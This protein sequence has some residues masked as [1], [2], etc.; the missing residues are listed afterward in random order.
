MRP[1]LSPRRVA[2]AGTGLMV[3]VLLVF[4]AV[5]L[6]ERG[7]RLRVERQHSELLARVLEDHATRT[8]ESVSLTLAALAD[9]V[10][11]SGPE[12]ENLLGDVL[13]RAL[14]GVPS[15]RSLALLDVRGRVLASTVA[16]ERGQLV[17][18]QRLA[19]LPQAQADTLGGFVAGRSLAAVAPGHTP[20]PVPAGVG[21]VPM[22]RLAVTRGG[23]GRLLVAL[24]NP[25]AMANYQQQVLSDT[26]RTAVLTTLDG[27]V[28]AATTGTPATPGQRLPAL[29]VFG[30]FLPAHE[31]GSYH[32]AGVGAGDRIVAFRASRS[33]PLV[34]IVELSVAEGLTVWRRDMRWM[35]LGVAL[36]VLLMGV[37]TLTAVRSLR[38]HAQARRQRDDAQAEVALRERELS[39]IFKSVQELLFRTDAQGRLSFVNTR[40]Q[41]ASGYPETQALGHSLADLVCEESRQAATALF[42]TDGPDGARTARLLLGRGHEKRHFDVAVAPLRSGSQLVG[43]AG[44]AVDV[45][46]AHAVQKRLAAQLAF[47]ELLLEVMPLPLVTLDTEGRYVTV[48]RAFEEFRNL[49]R[50]Q[51]LGRKAGD[52]LPPEEARLH[53]AQDTEL[54][55]KG[56]RVR[57]EASMAHQDGS[58]RDLAITKATVPGEGGQPAG[59]LVA[60]MDVSEF[61]E[62]E[63][64]TREAR[65]AAEE[66]SRAKSEFVAN[67]SHELRTPLQSIIGFSELGQMRSGTAVKLGA[68]FGDIH[69]AGQRMLALVNDLLD[70]SKIESTVGTFH[71]ERTDVRALVRDVVGELKQLLGARRLNVS[72]DLSEGALV[73]KVDP[74][75]FQQVVRNVMANAIRF[76]PEG[77]TIAIAGHIDDDNRI[78]IT[79]ADHGPGIPPAELDKIFEAFVQSSKTKD[80]SGGT[81]LGL[82]ICRKILQ[83]H[84]GEIRASNNADGGSTFH[85][86]LPAR[87]FAET[88]TGA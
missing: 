14:V 79:V 4:A 18:L 12:D 44:S 29:P 66:A 47:T 61:R 43:F 49:P 50:E 37:M 55:R 22:L 74:T 72:L 13:T 35:G 83:A 1:G 53:A 19:A 45:T 70:V 68:M 84:G 38:A 71:L 28:L 11:R 39:V 33:R 5:T 65:D 81:G 17:E 80:G 2:L 64:A 78:H 77:Q 73:A 57:Y 58:H 26:S 34:A 9:A 75:R 25:D 15:L 27:L 88:Q 86:L 7:E 20:E 32:G 48:N 63:H 67:I 31:F 21:F 24:I 42:A 62:A 8:V 40:W 51:C 3:L 23:E 30:Q 56:G 54:L 16:S 52:F 46:D 76:S 36:V 87:G 82:A 60:Y 6:R 69:A 59:I 10:A 41:A 85:I